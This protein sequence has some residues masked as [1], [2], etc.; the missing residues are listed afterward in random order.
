[1]AKKSKQLERDAF[2]SEHIFRLLVSNVTDYA[3]YMLK[4]D[5]IVANW[6][7]GGERIKGYAPEEIIGQSF[8]RFYTPADQAS[9]KPARAL[10]IAEETGH[11][12]EEGWRVRKDG[13]FFW[14]SVVIDPI[15]DADG[16]L[17][18][19][20]K[21]TRDISER[22]EAQQKLEQVQR[23]L[24]ESQ[25]MDA[26]GQLTGGVAHDFNNLLM[27]ISGNL[28]KIRQEVSSERGL[29]AL[30]AIETA[31]Q[32]AASLTSQLL[33][34]ARR[35]SVNPQ[36]IDVVARIGA[37]REVLTSALGSMIR[38]HI[39]IRPGTW[40]IHVDPAEFETALINLVVNA[41]D[42]MADGGT[43]TVSARN[44][45]ASNQ[46]VISVADTGD[47]IP[48]DVLSKVFDPFFT[49]KPVGKG[50]GL[51]LSQVHG[52]AH[53]A[54]G[55][56]EIATELGQGTT[57]SIHLP[58]GRSRERQVGEGASGLA[59]ATVLLVEDNPAVAD[60]ST[61]LL[62]QL[63]YTVRW[64]S[65]AESAL[66]AIEANGVDVVFSDIIMPGKMDGLKL[67]RAI[68]EKNPD[69]PIL[70]TTGYSDSMREVRSDFPVLRKPYQ[71]HDLSRELSKL[72]GQD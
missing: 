6:N 14:A 70:L 38:L 21:I 17:V 68:R 9:G 59:C 30:G 42:A 2:E 10:K 43:L 8:S 57:V 63:G 33:S 34:F 23:Q 13:S 58:R 35:Q 24:A 62:E 16:V 54:G 48:D 40:P 53:Q 47:G 41:R 66:Q 56:I 27:I 67:A 51:G 3:L 26:L 20:A 32:R 37:L 64:V 49:T 50:T 69:L 18:G 60:A 46:V 28:H 45:A 15:R 11:Y 29:R 65:S 55:K 72:T 61:G 52:F 7:A 12:E 44:Q 19:F 22:R 31:S 25:K 4:P 5:G 71:L 1:M 36:A 39:D